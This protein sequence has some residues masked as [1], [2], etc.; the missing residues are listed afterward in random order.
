MNR[1]VLVS[2]AVVA[3]V[4]LALSLSNGP[5]S[6]GAIAGSPTPS[7]RT[8][9]PTQ[10]QGAPTFTAPA[11][12]TANPGST[13]APAS[14]LPGIVFG[15]FIPGAPSDATKI[16]D[17]ADLIGSMPRIVMWYQTWADPYNAFFAAGADAIRARGAMPMISWE[18]RASHQNFDPEWSLTTIID[19]DHDAF[20]RQWAR[21][22][23]AWGQPLY[24]RL[25]HE[26][27]GQWTSWSPG[28]NGNTAPEFVTAWRHVIEIT[29]AEGAANVRWIWCPNID[30]G[31]PSFTPY[32]QLYPGDDYVD[33]VGLT[34]YNWGTSQRWSV[35]RDL[36]STFKDSI[37]QIRAITGKPLMIAEMASAEQGGDK[38]G[39]I[40]DGFSRLTTDL[41]DVKAVV[42][43]DTFDARLGTHWEVDSSPGSLAAYRAV[44]ASSDF[45]GTLP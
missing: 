28:L 25:M 7:T 18:P 23:A 5:D 38:G 35:W 20:V 11:P 22:V 4:V 45:G 10:T 2:T 9:G 43:F 24:V 44:A 30:D 41:P 14:P 8:E 19:G 29:R 39:W 40:S 3:V 17:F 42:W 16:D 6:N 13:L 1:W 26:M 36:T 31:N 37:D 34:G 33:W 12:S 15:A 27:N 32:E 21:D